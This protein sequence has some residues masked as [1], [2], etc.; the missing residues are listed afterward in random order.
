MPSI[1]A[2]DFTGFNIDFVEIGNAGN[3]ADDTGY[4]SVDYNYRLSVHEVSETMIDAYNT[5]NPNLLITK[6]TRGP[7]HPATSVSWNEAA[8]F[9]NWLNTS[10]G[11]SPAYKF[12]TT[13][14]ANDNIAL[15]PSADPGYNPNNP[16]RNSNAHYFLSSENE[17]YKA[18]YYNASTSTYHNYTTGS[19]TEPIAVASGTAGGTIVY[20][21]AFNIGPAVITNAGCLSPY[22]TMAQNG[23]V[24]EWNESSLTAPNDSVSE[25]RVSR[26]GNWNSIP[27]HLQPNFRGNLEPD[28]ATSETGFRVAAIADPIVYTDDF[29]ASSINPFWSMRN[30]NTTTTLQNTTVHEGHQAVKFTTT[31]SGQKEAH[32]EHVFSRKH[33]GKVSVWVYD[34]DPTQYIYFSLMV[35]DTSSDASAGIGVQDWDHSAYYSV[36][37]KTSFARTA[38]WHQFT[39]EFSESSL[40]TSIDGEVVYSGNGG[41]RFNKVSLNMFGPGSTG[42]VY[43]DDF[44]FESSQPQIQIEL[45]TDTPVAS[46][47][48]WNGGI[49]LAKESESFPLTIRNTGEGLLTDLVATMEGADASTFSFTIPNGTTVT[50]SGSTN[51]NLIASPPS[52][53]IKTAT[54]RITSNDASTPFYLIQ[55]NA[56]SLSE[57]DD[58]DQDGMNDAGEYSLR[59]FGFDWQNPQSSLVSKFYDRAHT[60]GLYTQE[61]AAGVAGNMRIFD[62]NPSTNT[63]DLIIRL[64]QSLNLQDFTQMTLNPAN[65]SIDSDG[66]IRYQHDTSANKKFF[67]AE[68]KGQ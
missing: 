39:I 16:F 30:Q 59:D 60:V 50:P 34:L 38:G 33:E 54:L 58:T 24:W 8:R 51:F 21:Q 6:D 44:L 42:I 2:D 55:L 31:T 17:W 68:W 61:Q 64:E 12:T 19:D 27:N 29:E 1:Q 62:V 36:D 26:G 32:L 52:G 9:V 14:G 49:L 25:L 41:N 40:K 23:N 4:G 15:W 65:L 10:T 11:H 56:Q 7:N 20:N 46:G 53:G 43:Y 37:G 35:S 18:A 63:V 48:T 5:A 28:D 22:G 66:N 13:G 3:A 47:G 67:R 57:E 45:P